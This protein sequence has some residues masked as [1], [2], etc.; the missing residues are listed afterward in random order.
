M[1]L[2]YMKD[3]KSLNESEQDVIFKARLALSQHRI[4]TR[5]ARSLEQSV[6]ATS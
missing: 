2:Q 5:E 3:F 1:I 6:N 4:G